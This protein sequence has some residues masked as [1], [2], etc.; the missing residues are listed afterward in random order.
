MQRELQWASGKL[1]GINIL[2]FAAPGRAA[3][4]GE[5]KKA[6]AL[7]EQALQITKE[8]NFKDNAAGVAAFAALLEAEVG[9]FGQAR[10]R[11]ATSLALSR[12]PTNL[13]AIAVALALAGDSKQAQGIVD[14]LHRRY[15]DTVANDVFIPCAQALLESNRGDPA[16]GIQG[17][18]VA[19]R[20]ELGPVYSFL[21]IYV[22][23][24]IYLHA[25]RG[26]E[27]AAEFQRILN[28]R[29]LGAIAPA[30]ALSHVGL[31][32]AYAL[33]GDSAKSRKAYQDF[34]ALWKDAEPD[35]PILKEAKAEYAKLQYI[36]IR[37]P[38]LPDAGTDGEEKSRGHRP[39]RLI[40]D[41][42]AKFPPIR[43]HL[44]PLP[45]VGPMPRFVCMILLLVATALAQDASTGAIRGS[46]FDSTGGRSHGASVAL[47]NAATGI[48]YGV[49]TDSERRFAFD[50]LPPGRYS[51][52]AEATGM[53]PQIASNL[54]VEV[55]VRD[56]E[57][58]L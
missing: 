5:L 36:L 52:R 56:L 9:N 14:E 28:Y 33:T 10:G 58:K 8:N 38:E 18:Q 49:I 12:K 22:R 17:L 6:R 1:A 44:N 15:P 50:L 27:A 41:I 21:P 34:F 35:V 2:G 51:A 16:Q 26:Q 31:A 37:S 13:P 29:A 40:S 4:L 20:Y 25:R 45:G 19:S 43:A 48:R 47:V 3:H 46:V 30:Y 42:Q 57:F 7:S 32:R 11:A 53:S 55:G 54:R 24:L 23:G 39:T